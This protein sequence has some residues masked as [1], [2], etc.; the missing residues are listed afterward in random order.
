MNDDFI[1]GQNYNQ[2]EEQL[3]AKKWMKLIGIILILLLEHLFSL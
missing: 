3:K 2:T 1:G